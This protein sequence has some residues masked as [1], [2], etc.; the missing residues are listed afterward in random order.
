MFDCFYFDI[1]QGIVCVIEAGILGV[2]T[3]TPFSSESVSSSDALPV[4]NDF[5][6][7]CKIAAVLDHP[8]ICVPTNPSLR[9]QLA[10]WNARQGI[11]SHSTE[12]SSEKEA[13][14]VGFFCGYSF[15]PDMLVLDLGR[16]EFENDRNF[17]ADGSTIM[18]RSGI[19]MHGMQVFS[20][21]LVVNRACAGT[22]QDSTLDL[23]FSP[24]QSAPWDF[25]LPSSQPQPVQSRLSFETLLVLPT[26]VH[27]SILRRVDVPSKPANYHPQTDICITIDTIE[28]TMTPDQY[29]LLQNVLFENVL[30]PTNLPWRVETEPTSSNVSYHLHDT[31]TKSEEF[32]FRVGINT[33]RATL[34][35]EHGISF[36]IA[37]ISGFHFSTIKQLDGSTFS[38]VLM[39][40]LWLLDTKLPV[41]SPGYNCVSPGEPRIGFTPPTAATLFSPFTPLPVAEIDAGT[42]EVI[43]AFTSN[44]RQLNTSIVIKNPVGMLRPEFLSDLA[45]FFVNAFVAA[46]ALSA[47]T[48]TLSTV[49]IGDPS[50]SHE[51]MT[52]CL[53]LPNLEYHSFH[54]ASTPAA[55]SQFKISI[56]CARLLLVNDV[57]TLDAPAIAAIGTY[58]FETYSTASN[59]MVRMKF[60][61]MD[62]QCHLCDVNH[63]ST[64]E[65]SSMLFS[66]TAGVC[67]IFTCLGEQPMWFSAAALSARPFGTVQTW[68]NLN[69][70]LDPIRINLKLSSVVLINKI[71]DGWSRFSTSSL[72]PRISRSAVIVSS[73]AETTLSVGKGLHAVAS[74][75]TAL[76]IEDPSDL[77]S[78]E[79]PATTFDQISFACQNMAVTFFNEQFELQPLLL[80]E[81]AETSFQASGRSGR[82]C[83]AFRTE[84]VASCFSLLSQDWYRFLASWAS[85]I[86]ITPGDEPLT[87][88]TLQGKPLEIIISDSFLL[89]LFPTIQKW[90]QFASEPTPVEGRAAFLAATTE[91]QRKPLPAAGVTCHNRTERLRVELQLDAVQIR[92]AQNQS[93]RLNPLLQVVLKSLALDF[94]LQ[95]NGQAIVLASVQELFVFDLKY[96]DSSKFYCAIASYLHPKYVTALAPLPE[97]LQGGLGPSADNSKLLTLR[98][99]YDVIAATTTI[100]LAFGHLFCQWNPDSVISL[101]TWLAFQSRILAQSATSSVEAELSSLIPLTHQ[102]TDLS[103][104][105]GDTI[106]FPNI[107]ISDC[108]TICESQ[109]HSMKLTIKLDQWSVVFNKD[110]EDRPLFQLLVQQVNVQYNRAH[111]ACFWTNGSLGNL[112]VVDLNSTK[113]HFPA[114]V[115]SR[116]GQDSLGSFSFYSLKS[117]ATREVWPTHINGV[118]ALSVQSIRIVYL[119]PIWSEYLDYVNQGVLGVLIS[120]EAKSAVET[121]SSSSFI[122]LQLEVCSW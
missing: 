38:Q 105:V 16:I 112:Q 51:Q 46:P 8:L 97:F 53:T 55:V 106:A 20:R 95:L 100:D 33:V 23:K 79:S 13:V 44:Q 74:G 6:N 115:S 121:S 73:S 81:L 65:T 19:A 110:V 12:S 62:V 96:P 26:D 113:S 111:N 15:G 102:V 78:N 87:S 30:A 17:A 91:K 49:P 76:L 5:R 60:Q 2:L 72:R 63:I 83:F 70:Q 104:S 3:L 77:V 119:H 59:E 92:L 86:S 27:A 57:T 101:M 22:S 47:P 90:L 93:E 50:S 114:L 116:T 98:C 69:I 34:Q 58:H 61:A 109:S 40:E 71:L 120:S 36:A 10:E 4:L 122:Q 24:P 31:A 94:R 88:I 108:E 103:A 1:S 7:F 28:V 82:Y 84:I 64:R 25:K 39:A 45:S 21:E 89:D 37:Q 75:A 11:H 67:D 52:H 18:D 43:V 9:C 54:K 80:F 68:R 29:Q 42:A 35:S 41:Q 56:E 32:K 118:C 48:S 99:C 117:D 66:P 14:G 107:S 85:Q